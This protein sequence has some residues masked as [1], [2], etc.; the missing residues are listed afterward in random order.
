ML[1]ACV[2]YFCADDG[3][4]HERGVQAGYRQPAAAK[5]Q[6]QPEKRRVQES[7]LPILHKRR[8]IVKVPIHLPKET[9]VKSCDCERGNIN[10]EY[11]TVQIYWKAR[12]GDRVKKGEAVCEAQVEKAVIDVLSPADGVLVSIDVEEGEEAEA[13]HILGFIEK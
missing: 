2:L 12:L 3:S 7:A 6:L 13:D 9:N 4:V 11:K 10:I 8:V 5:M 1:Q